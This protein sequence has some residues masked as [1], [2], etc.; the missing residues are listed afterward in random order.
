MSVTTPLSLTHTHGYKRDRIGETARQDAFW[1]EDQRSMCPYAI[2]LHMWL[3]T[4]LDQVWPPVRGLSAPQLAAIVQSTQGQQ[5][6]R[7]DVQRDN[8]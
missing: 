8:Q 7:K 5:Q 6:L 1:R 2:K 3:T 4:H